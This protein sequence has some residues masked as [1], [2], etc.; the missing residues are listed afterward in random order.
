MRLRKKKP[1]GPARR[2]TTVQTR[3]AKPLLFPFPSNCPESGPSS[4]GYPAASRSAPD[5]WPVRSG[6]GGR[7]GQAGERTSERTGVRVHIRYGR[8]GERANG[9]R[10]GVRGRAR[11][12]GVPGAD[13]DGR[14][15]NRWSGGRACRAVPHAVAVL[16]PLPGPGAATRLQSGGQSAVLR[17]RAVCA[18]ACSCS[19]VSC[20]VLPAVVGARCVPAVKTTG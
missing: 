9:R 6:T 20:C 11:W 5:T 12:C 18:K 13:G 10:K 16:V 7:G 15:W 4:N 1:V 14:N 3:Q 19:P 8:T 17:A 2:E